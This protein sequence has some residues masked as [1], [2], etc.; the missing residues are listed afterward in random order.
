MLESS[1]SASVC[2]V[3]EKVT[4]T[5]S[6]PVLMTHPVIQ[7]LTIRSVHLLVIPNSRVP[8]TNHQVTSESFLQ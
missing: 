5:P 7:N 2:I 4:H 6:D 8:F 3:E 1:I